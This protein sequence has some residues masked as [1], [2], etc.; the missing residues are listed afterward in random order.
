MIGMIDEYLALPDRERRMY[1]AARRT[2]RVIRP[3]DMKRLP[4]TELE[5][6]G[7]IADSVDDPYEWE[8]KMN[9]LISRYI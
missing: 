1:Q 3:D 9:S 7:K 6:L 8:V 5:K 4:A 2:V